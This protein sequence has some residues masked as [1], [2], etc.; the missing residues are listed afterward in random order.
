[1]QKSLAEEFNKIAAT[2]HNAFPKELENLVVFLLPYSETPVYVAPEAADLLAK[3]PI[4]I[5]EAVKRITEYMRDNNSSG[6]SDNNSYFLRKIKTKVIAVEED[7]FSPYYPL[8]TKEMDA[9]GNLIHEIGHNVVKN[10]RSIFGHSHLSECAADSY[11]LLRHIQ[12]FGNGTDFSKHHCNRA[13]TVVLGA[14]SRHYTDN[15][16]EKIK[17]LSE[18]INISELSLHK[19]AELAEKIA[20]ENSLDEETLKKIGEAFFPVAKAYEKTG[21]WNTLWWNKYLLQKCFEVMQKHQNDPDIFKAGE[22]FFN[23]PD[24]KKT[25]E[26]MAKTDSRWKDALNFIKNHQ[27]KPTQKTSFS[28]FSGLIMRGR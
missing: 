12:L 15:I 17:Q 25:L 11:A 13:H 9:T 4:A 22:R 28:N 20:Q 21:G 5:K 23:K 10:G 24:I 19:T 3:N 6:V 18:E 26:S 7:H 16:I 2:E 14:S 27:I 8:Y 1:M